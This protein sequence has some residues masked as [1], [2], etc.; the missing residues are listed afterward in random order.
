MLPTQSEDHLPA[1]PP[2]APGRRQSS[3]GGGL[4]RLE[5]AELGLPNERGGGK[6]NKTAGDGGL[7]GG[8]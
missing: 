1:R 2:P 5:W 7:A 8:G 3:G 4:P 6:G